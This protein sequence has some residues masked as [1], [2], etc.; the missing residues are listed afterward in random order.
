MQPVGLASLATLAR[1]LLGIVDRA[2]QVD[3]LEYFACARLFVKRSLQVLVNHEANVLRHLVHQLDELARR[4]QNSFEFGTL[5]Q[6]L[7]LLLVADKRKQC[8]TGGCE[9]LAWNH[10]DRGYRDDA[11]CRVHTPHLGHTPL[12]L[13]TAKQFLCRLDT[14]TTRYHCIRSFRATGYGSFFGTFGADNVGSGRY[15]LTIQVE[16][17][18][19][20]RFA[21]VANVDHQVG[22]GDDE[23]TLVEGGVDLGGQLVTKDTRGGESA[24]VRVV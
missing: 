24:A 3:N 18:V 10:C 2:A 7:E 22:L 9:K 23:D 12:H 13:T 8:L 20:T 4:G 14:R 1:L 16:C 15:A 5:V 21:V 17:A 6:L 19:R 11:Q